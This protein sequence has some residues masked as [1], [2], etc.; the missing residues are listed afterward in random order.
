MGGWA[1]L[2]GYQ[3]G[4]PWSAHWT[5]S[6]VVPFTFWKLAVIVVAPGAL[7]SRQTTATHTVVDSRDS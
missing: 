6:V 3:R 5:V 1:H 7:G 4:L 2:P